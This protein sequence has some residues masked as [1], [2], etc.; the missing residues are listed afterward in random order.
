MD[1]DATPQRW[2]P[3]RWQDL[4]LD[5][6]VPLIFALLTAGFFALAAQ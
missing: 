5:V 1:A 6:T 4:F 3:N 2:T